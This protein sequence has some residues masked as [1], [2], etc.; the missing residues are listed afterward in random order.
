MKY[1]NIYIENIY[2]TNALYVCGCNVYMEMNINV[3]VHVW[4]LVWRTKNDI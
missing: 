1:I 4:A 2:T 3:Q